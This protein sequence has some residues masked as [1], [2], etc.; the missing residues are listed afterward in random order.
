MA[1]LSIGFGA[2][3]WVTLAAITVFVGKS[4]L[5]LCLMARYQKQM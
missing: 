3:L 4:V 5:E 1:W 2:P